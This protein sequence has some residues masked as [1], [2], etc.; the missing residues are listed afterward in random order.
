MLDM[1]KRQVRRHLKHSNCYRSRH[2][3]PK[4]FYQ[5]TKFLRSRRHARCYNYGVYSTF[6]ATENSDPEEDENEEPLLKEKPLAPEV[7]KSE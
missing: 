6:N 4:Y 7:K 5:N 2:V 3:T 1:V